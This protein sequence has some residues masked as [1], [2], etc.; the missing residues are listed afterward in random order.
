MLASTKVRTVTPPAMRRPLSGAFGLAVLTAFSA[1]AETPNSEAAPFIQIASCPDELLS[2]LPGV[3]RLEIEV[4]LRERGATRAPPDRIGVRC[5]ADRAQIEVTMA[6]STQ[7]SSI[8]LGVLAAEHRARAV[9]LAAAELVHS[10]STGAP[11]PEPPAPPPVPTAP[12]SPE[13]PD[14]AAPEPVLRR[15]KPHAA[16]FFGPL[17]ELLGKP[18]APLLGARLALQVPVG[19]VVVPTLSADGGFG[20]VHARS[21]QVKIETAGAA[22]HLY[23]GTTS[24]RVRWELGP[25]ARIGYVHLAGEPADGSGLEGRTLAAAWGGAEARARVAFAPVHSPAFALELGAGYVTWP[26][27]GLRDGTERIYSV[28]GPWASFC[29]EVGLDL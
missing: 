5:E 7:S 15:Q 10:M 11:R 9:A 3:I 29:A 16:L 20:G 4:L 19:S 27:R 25:G 23:V 2:R 21:A 24:A 13:P 26:V 22:A 12:P 28:E 17:V 6:G 18:A 14:R 1:H 8:D